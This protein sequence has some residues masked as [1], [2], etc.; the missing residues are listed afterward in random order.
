MSDPIFIY[1]KG[2]ESGMNIIKQTGTANTTYSKG[3]TISYIVEHYTAGVSSKKGSARSTA[4]WFGRSE[5]QASA[6]FIV[7]D[8]EIVQYN[9]DIRNRYCWA[10]GG[11]KYNT[12]GGSL[13]GIAKNSNCISIEICSTNSTGRITYPND[14]HY[15]V[16]EAA[17]NNAVALTKYLMKEYNIDVNHVIRHYDVNGK[18]CLG[19]I[20]WNA[21]S[22]DESK[23]KEF[24]AKI[25]GTYEEPRWYRVR[26][27]WADANSQLGAYQVLQN[28]KDNCPYGYAVFDEKGKEVYRP[29]APNLKTLQAKD[30]NGLSEAQ[31]IATVAPIY[32]E[33]MKE[34]GM[35]AS[36]GLAQFCLESGYSTTDLA[37]NANNMHGM[38]CS[39]SGNTWAN[40]VWD[41]KSKY[42]KYSPEVYNGVTQMVYSEFRKYPAIYKSVQD[43]AAYFIGAWLDA[44]KTKHRYPNVNMIKDAETQVK[45][46]KSGGYATDPNYV[47]KLLNIINR[48]NLTQYDKGITPTV[49]NT[50]SNAN[51]A[52]SE[53]SSSTPA[54]TTTKPA[55]T[56]KKTFYRVQ[57][58]CFS[59][60][61][62]RDKLIKK[63]KK[64]LDLDCFYEVVGGN[65]YVYCGSFSIRNVAEQRVTE[66]KSK[67]IDAFIKPVT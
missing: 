7:D 15:S 61:K 4:S 41:G 22:G 33:V 36:V 42:G 29:D 31:K 20:G 40:S 3:R 5:A 30:L 17:V 64:K 49:W 10:V 65:Y 27:T 8:A 66:L 9:G 62:K 23:W 6:D 32:Q 48:F 16:T 25:G 55:T 53:P 11:G 19:V 60:I 26:R 1:Y 51:K 54:Q 58:G 2:G 63:I 52:T 13:Y 14:P 47:S 59:T 18:P 35:L 24:K 28:A 38:K 37:Q 12:K 34:T 56:A 39:L 43:R 21:D 44:A 45:L 50:S 46:L 57:V 67:K